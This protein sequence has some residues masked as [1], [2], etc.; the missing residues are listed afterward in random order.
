M[1][2]QGREE[3]QSLRTTVVLEYPALSSYRENCAEPIRIE[4]ADL[5]VSSILRCHHYM[6]P[7]Q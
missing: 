7:P 5:R 3:Q 4:P 6:F 2:E 1:N